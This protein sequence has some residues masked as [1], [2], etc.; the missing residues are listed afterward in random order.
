MV[1]I[2]FSD[3]GRPLFIVYTSLVTTAR[4]VFNTYF[5]SQHSPLLYVKKKTGWW[6]L[7]SWFTYPRGTMF[8]SQPGSS[9]GKEVNSRWTPTI[10]LPHVTRLENLG[11]R[12][13]F[14]S[15]LNAVWW[16]QWSPHQWT[17]SYCITGRRLSSQPDICCIDRFLLG[18]ERTATVF[19]P[20]IWIV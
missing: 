1:Y 6:Q 20:A 12:S 7:L 19:F 16:R 15:R 4:L 9:W 11:S 17:V 13:A 14:Y 18:N 10:L 8:W 5:L 2:P 3:T